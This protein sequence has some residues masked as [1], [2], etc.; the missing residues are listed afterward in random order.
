MEY[1]NYILYLGS[2]HKRKNV[3]G[4]IKAFEILKEKHKIFHK[5]ILAGPD[6]GSPTSH[7]R[8]RTS[9]IF[10]NHVDEKKKWELLK[11]ADIFVFPSF[12]EGFG[13][14]VLEAQ[15][16]GTAVVAS[17][18]GA[19]PETLEDSA[20][21]V[22]PKDPSQIAKGIYKLLS[23]EKFKKEL[24]EKGYENTKRF[25]WPKCAEETLKIITL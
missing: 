16:T 25:S 6:V 11:N 8:G 13:F 12:Y 18:T 9:V 2:G 24:I 3:G 15:K 5:L 23:N 19:L 20:L 10:T 7:M 4:L 1:K 22:N 21:L 17:N 14:P